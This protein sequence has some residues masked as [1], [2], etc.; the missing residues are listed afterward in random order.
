MLAALYRKTAFLGLMAG[1]ILTVNATDRASQILLERAREEF[2]A[3]TPRFIA[4]NNAEALGTKFSILEFDSNPREAV[5]TAREIKNSFYQSLA[6]GGIAE[7]EIKSDL[8]SSTSH[9]RE[10][11][12]CSLK[13]SHWTGPHA[14]SLN[15]LFEL[16]PTFPRDTSLALL[17]ASKEAF[18]SWRASDFQKQRS[19]LALAKATAVVE[20]SKCEPLL[21]EVALESNHY[22]DSIEYLAAFL[23]AKAPE[24]MLREAR[25]RYDEGKN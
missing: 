25:Q 20:P 10:A 3:S 19:L 2:I 8:T 6:L 13:I 7:K 24:K 4:T 18:D 1:P 21:Y 16:V 23:A 17:S 12:D 11:L 5:E 22:W 9:Y 15:F 14:S